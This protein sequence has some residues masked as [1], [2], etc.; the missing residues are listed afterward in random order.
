MQ[1]TFGD[2][3]NSPQLRRVIQTVF[4]T[5]KVELIQRPASFIFELKHEPEERVFR[6]IL[7]PP[8]GYTSNEKNQTS[9]HPE[10]RQAKIEIKGG[11][12]PEKS[13]FSILKNILKYQYY[14]KR[15]IK[16]KNSLPYPKIG[17]KHYHERVKSAKEKFFVVRENGTGFYHNLVNLSNEWLLLVLNKELRIQKTPDVKS[18]VQFLHKKDQ[19][20]FLTLY[21]QIV[22]HGDEL[23]EKQKSLIARISNFD[24]AQAIPPLIEMLNVL[25]TGKHEP[26]S[27]FG[28][29]LK[30]S[31]QN[32]KLASTY[33]KEAVRQNKAP[34]YYLYELLKK[35]Q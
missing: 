32:K 33:L 19:K 26:C 18:S 11:I 31:K 9:P 28:I 13:G 23:F 1:V 16:I 35:L 4:D 10:V 8:H 17:G 25:E 12:K 14:T 15:D 22:R 5:K 24:V 7:L 21:N 27:V 6:I 20:T 3:E 2:I 30:I 34:R 29:I